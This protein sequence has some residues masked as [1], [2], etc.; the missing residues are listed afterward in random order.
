MIAFPIRSLTGLRPDT[1]NLVAGCIHNSSSARDRCASAWTSDDSGR[2]DSCKKSDL[3]LHNTSS[4]ARQCACEYPFRHYVWH[5]TLAL[6]VNQHL[7]APVSEVWRLWTTS[8]GA[9]GFFA[10]RWISSSQFG[11]PYEIQFDPNDETSGTKGLKIL[12]YAPERGS[13]QNWLSPR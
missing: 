5:L 7:D 11:G 10:Q 3:I 1:L 13:A 12:S 4:S 6:V 8:Q 9:E 2:G